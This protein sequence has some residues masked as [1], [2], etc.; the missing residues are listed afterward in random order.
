MTVKSKRK[1]IRKVGGAAAKKAHI[2]HSVNV[3]F[4]QQYFV[5]GCVISYVDNIFGVRGTCLRFPSSH[6]PV[7]LAKLTV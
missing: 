3:I 2:V 6:K 5:A 1:G 4:Q 7:T